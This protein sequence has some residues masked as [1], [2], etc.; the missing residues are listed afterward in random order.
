MSIGPIGTEMARALAAS[1]T[2]APATPDSPAFGAS[3]ADSLGRVDQSLR[4]ADHAIT[5][6]A[7]GQADHIHQAMIALEQANLGL[8]LTL[9]IRNKIVA[10]YDEISRMQL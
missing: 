7:T 4:G 9:Q 5:A 10:A 3:L 8:E 1:A 2:A 6:L